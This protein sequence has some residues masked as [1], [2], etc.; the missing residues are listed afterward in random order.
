MQDR[1]PGQLT[2]RL[3]CGECGT[4]AELGRQNFG[5]EKALQLVPK[6]FAQ[7]GWYVGA[8]ERDDRCPACLERVKASRAA[9]PALHLVPSTPETP[10]P[11]EAPMSATPKPVVAEPPREMRRDDRRVIF[12]KLE[13]IYLDETRGYSAGWSDQRVAADLGV[14]RAWVSQIREE[15]FGPGISEDAT[16]FVTELREARQ[17]LTQLTADM[18]KLMGELTALKAREAKLVERIGSLEKLGAR[19]AA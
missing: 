4:E 2:Y 8:R 6:K 17:G 18:G 12:A 3:T 1:G 9:R 7:K 13:E 19:L 10:A 11:V 5:E 15:N 14:P 16:K